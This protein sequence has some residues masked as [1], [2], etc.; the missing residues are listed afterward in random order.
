MGTS[1]RASEEA[2]TN[3]LIY[4]KPRGTWWDGYYQQPNIILDDF[5][6]WIPYDELFKILDRYPYRVL[7]I[8]AFL[9]LELFLLLLLSVASIIWRSPLVLVSQADQIPMDWNLL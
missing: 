5:N 8:E 2:K 6:G 3:E 1:R 9:W 4:Y 7:A